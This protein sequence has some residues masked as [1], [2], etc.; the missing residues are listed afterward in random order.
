MVTEILNGKKFSKD[1][2]S[3]NIKVAGLSSEQLNAAG[4]IEQSHRKAAN[5]VVLKTVMSERTPNGEP[6]TMNDTVRAFVAAQEGFKCFA[7]K[8]GKF[9]NDLHSQ[10]MGKNDKVVFGNFSRAALKQSFSEQS[11]ARSRL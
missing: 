1:L 6:T 8:H 2:L 10:A 4:L 9:W 5:D 7:E 3:E 11:P